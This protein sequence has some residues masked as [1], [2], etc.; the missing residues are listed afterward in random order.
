MSTFPETLGLGQVI[1]RELKEE[2]EML[3]ASVYGVYELEK[4]N[5]ELKQQLAEREKQIAM[6]RDA[7]LA[8]CC[9]PEGTVCI[10]G[11]DGDREV[12]QKALAATDNL[13]GLILCDVE[14][15]SWISQEYFTAFSKQGFQVATHKI[16]PSLVPLY[17]AKKIGR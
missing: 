11:S 4:E 1:S 9:D 13:S 15:V 17:K 14:P 6:L 7:I 5:D 8:V 16:S 2:I 10:R 3:K 12:L